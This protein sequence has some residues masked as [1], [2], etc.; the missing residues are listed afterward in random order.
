[1]AAVLPLPELEAAE[2]RLADLPFVLVLLA[3]AECQAPTLEVV[4]LLV[5]TEQADAVM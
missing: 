2:P 3:V 4:D 1:M 5:P